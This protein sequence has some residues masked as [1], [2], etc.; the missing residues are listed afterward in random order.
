MMGNEDSPSLSSEIMSTSVLNPSAPVFVSTSFK[1]GCMATLQE[2]RVKN[3]GNIIIAE[4]NINSL[5][6]KFD[7]L[8]ELV[9]GKVDVLVICE[10]KLDK[11][12][13]KNTFL[14]DGYKKPYR[15]D[16]NGDG[17]ALLSMYEQIF[18][19]RKKRTIFPLMYT[20][21]F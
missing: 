18:Q 2:T 10:T 9:R 11:T 13:T 8:V 6:N 16:R 7:S 15:K 5:R 3:V 12:F 1:K 21:S 19:V 4:L 20:I 14:I 17:G